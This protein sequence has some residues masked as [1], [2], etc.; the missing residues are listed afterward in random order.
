MNIRMILVALP[1]LLAGCMAGP[2]PNRNPGP[3]PPH[4]PHD[5]V[6]GQIGPM[7]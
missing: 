3:I 6:P 7:R 4:I 2:V 1:L 5:P